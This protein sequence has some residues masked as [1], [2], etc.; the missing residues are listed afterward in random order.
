MTMTLNRSMTGV[1]RIINQE[2][3]PRKLTWSG[4]GL[5]DAQETATVLV[6]IGAT[7]NVAKFMVADGLDEI[8][9]IQQFTRETISLYV[10]NSRKNLS[11]SDIVSTRFILDLEKVAFKMTHIKNRI[12]RVMD[13]ADID[14][15]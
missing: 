6:A 2:G 11:A 5:P 9:E 15:K 12:S 4:N 7:R 10:K 14:K 8:A 1:R 3:P 13:P